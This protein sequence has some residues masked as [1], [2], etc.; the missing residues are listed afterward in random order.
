MKC[1]HKKN[2]PVLVQGPCNPYRD[3]YADNKIAEVAE[4]DI[5]DVFSLSF[6]FE[7]VQLPLYA[8]I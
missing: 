3:A 7:H 6:I 2:P 4:C 1:V 5:H 8:S